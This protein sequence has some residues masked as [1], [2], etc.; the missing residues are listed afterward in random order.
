MEARE[1]VMLNGLVIKDY[2]NRLTQ[3]D[4]E[5]LWML[6]VEEGLDDGLFH[7]GGVTT[8]GDFA[9]FASAPERAFYAVFC[10]DAPAA[11]FW[12]DAR[13]GGA[14]RIHFAVYRRFHGSFGRII[15][16]YV[17]SWLLTGRHALDVLIGV[18]PRCHRLA[19]AFIRDIGF[20]VTGTVPH[21]LSLAGGR[22]TG[23]VISYITKQEV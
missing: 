9:A 19:L 14:A 13:Q 17:V 4:L 7:D 2:P 11:L 10:G 15:G 1:I 16:R 22:T 3:A 5:G 20:R 23:A 12:L 8:V 18:T 6:L 21:A